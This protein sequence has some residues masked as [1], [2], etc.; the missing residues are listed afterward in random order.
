MGSFIATLVIAIHEYI[1]G[2]LTFINTM[3]SLHRFEFKRH[4]CRMIF[5]STSIL[6]SILNSLIGFY[7]VIV[8][9]S[10]L[11]SQNNMGLD[12][13]FDLCFNIFPV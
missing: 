10:C 6:I 1:F 8:V 7:F 5:L 13:T 11:I 3:Y 2:A 12:I 4:A 9:A